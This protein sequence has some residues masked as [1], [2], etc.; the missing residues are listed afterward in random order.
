MTP[1]YKLHQNV[2][3]MINDKPA[4]RQIAGI[5][6]FPKHAIYYIY[7]NESEFRKE[8]DR[9]WLKSDKEDK[10]LL[11]KKSEE[12]YPTVD[13]LQKSIFGTMK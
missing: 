11:E 10:K 8:L 13:E 7:R 9:F 2:F 12:L 3:L 6:I 1:K 5:M 4:M